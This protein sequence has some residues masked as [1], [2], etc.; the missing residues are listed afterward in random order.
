MEA[1][2]KQEIVPILVTTNDAAKMLSVHKSTLLRM[3]K[4]GVIKK[5]N[6]FEKCVRF[7]RH[8]II[9]LIEK[10]CGKLTAKP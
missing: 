4:A 3:V 10:R 6:L 1:Y 8:E 2:M 7:Y 5:H 9:E